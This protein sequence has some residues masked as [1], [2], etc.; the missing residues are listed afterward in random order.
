MEF[1]PSFCENMIIPEIHKLAGTC[2]LIND[3]R[4]KEDEIQQLSKLLD[5]ESLFRF[6]Y[7][8]FVIAKLVWDYADTIL[9]IVSRLRIRETKALSRTIKTL[10]R[11]Y[12]QF[13]APYIDEFHE[14]SENEN[15]IVFEDGVSDI[16]A[17]MILNV[18][19]DLKMEYPDIDNDYM[20]LLIAVYQCDITLRALLLYAERQ[21][22]SVAKKLDKYVGPILPRQMY[23]LKALVIEF[24]G[25]MP[26]SERFSTLK[27]QYIETFAN[28]MALIELIKID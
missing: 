20:L 18:R 10:R 13:R 6:A 25:D 15:M 21:A 1:I 16:M 7:V 23:A 24:V 27:K 2:L 14:Q 19:C 4:Q 9:D 28:Q 26:P 8:P 12:E 11:E 3:T 5:N 22:E 17:Q